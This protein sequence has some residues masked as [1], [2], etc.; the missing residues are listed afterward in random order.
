MSFGSS[1]GNGTT[2]NAAGFDSG[3]WS[4]LSLVATHISPSGPWMIEAPGLTSA[5]SIPLLVP[6]GS[7]GRNPTTL[8]SRVTQR[9]PP[10]LVA[11]TVG[12]ATP[13]SSNSSTVQS[14]GVLA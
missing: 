7:D 5:I 1:P 9:L 4:R 6:F 3:K 14:G 11:I 2:L 12:T 13:S 10:E 8:A